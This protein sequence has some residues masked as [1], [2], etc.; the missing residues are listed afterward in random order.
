MGSFRQT[1][2]LTPQ[3][4]GTDNHNYA[5]T[6]VLPARPLKSCLRAKGS[7]LRL[8]GI[9]VKFGQDVDIIGKG[10]VVPLL[11]PHE[12]DS[13]LEFEYN[14]P[15][16]PSQT[17][18]QIP[19][20]PA[21]GGSRGSKGTMRIKGPSANIFKQLAQ[22]Q[23]PIEKREPGIMEGNLK[24]LKQT[25]MKSTWMKRYVVLH[26]KSLAYYRSADADK[27]LKSY[28]LGDDCAVKEVRQITGVSDCKFAL[29]FTKGR[30]SVVLKANDQRDMT[31]W[32]AGICSAVDHLNGD[33]HGSDSDEFSWEE[34]ETTPREDADKFSDFSMNTFSPV[35]KSF[36][37]PSTTATTTSTTTAS[38]PTSSLVTLSDSGVSTTTPTTAKVDAG[39][40][41]SDDEFEWVDEEEILKEQDEIAKN[42]EKERKEREEKLQ[43]EREAAAKLAKEQ[44]E[45]AR[46]ERERAAKLQQENDAAAKQTN[47]PSIQTPP[48]TRATASDVAKKTVQKE[49]ATRR[50]DSLLPAKPDDQKLNPKSNEL[51][52]TLRASAKAIPRGN[53][54]NLRKMWE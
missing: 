39:M 28:D 9:N 46:Q 47:A 5:M 23:T 53:V 35:P 31:R 29:E 15:T 50:P 30:N 16:G 34:E 2:R 7:P 25:G 36:K 45:K 11:P 51:P 1:S 33:L 12:V 19:S 44:E 32:I 37:Q 13:Q 18:S 4:F 6:E 21:A 8:S 41:S 52:Y 48:S 54:S 17:S 22:Q 49:V 10:Q 24:L 20:V 40:E 27:A 38:K 42:A 3:T 43:R 26:A 14:P